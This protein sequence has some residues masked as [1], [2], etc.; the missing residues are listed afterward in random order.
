M[1]KRFKELLAG[2]ELIP[3]FATGRMIHPVVIEIFGLAGGYRGFWIDQ[4]HVGVTSSDITVAALAGK[5][6]DMDCFVRMP[7]VGYWQVTQAYESGAGG[8]MAAQIN[9]AEQA[10][11]FVSW[12]KYAPEGT[13]GL[14]TGGRDADY[15][16]KS[17]ADVVVETNREH[18]VA[19]Q[20]ETLG[21]LEEADAIA[22]L[23]GVDLLFIGPA[24]L[25][26]ALGVVG[27]F[28]HDKVWEAIRSV[29]AACA[30][31]GKHWGAVI[32][33][34]EFG[35]RAL[36]DGCRMPTIGNDLHALRHGVLALQ[37]VHARQFE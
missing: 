28:N 32:P 16:F 19:I 14:N 26:L 33:N 37:D 10:R 5:A 6:H 11:E 9:S 17:L 30:R 4:E 8:V 21:A 29:A 7:P 3:L 15:T 36:D 35:G 2:D 23:G 31:H 22:A 18:F 1:M 25:S 20:I 34:A 12:A 24:D 13:R 27:Q